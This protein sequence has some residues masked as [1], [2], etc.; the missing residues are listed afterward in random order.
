M[1]FIHQNMTYT[2]DRLSLVANTS[3]NRANHLTPWSDYIRL[4]NWLRKRRDIKGLKRADLLTLRKTVK[5]TAEGIIALF[6]NIPSTP[7]SISS[8]CS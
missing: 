8:F 7:R 5:T 2:A 3:K 1:Y 4:V 6:R